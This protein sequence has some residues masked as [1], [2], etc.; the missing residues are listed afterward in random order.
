MYIDGHTHL[1][2]YDEGKLAEVLGEIERLGVLTLAVGMDGGSFER[3]RKIAAGSE[4]IV[5]C[6]G[7]HPWRAAEYV[8]KLE[9][10]RP[11]IDMSPMIG[12]IG[13]DFHWVE[14][15]STYPKQRRV[16]EF[17]LGEAAAQKKLVNL[18]TKGAEEEVADLLEKYGV[19]RS[20]I[21]WYSGPLDLVARLLKLGCYFTI[22]VEV[23]HSPLIQELAKMLPLERVLTETD[24]PG[25]LEWLT[26]EIGMP[27]HIP[28]V[29]AEIAR[30]RGMEVEAVREAVWENGRRVLDF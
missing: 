5:P 7:V 22:G 14:D 18:H 2:H 25:G 27:R 17:F 10:M 30:L 16:F 4:W 23:A 12:E 13:L 8:D 19:E 3:Q 26:G 21:H 9:E 28:E 1:D 20:L 15:K 24:G 6:F 29:V 11:L